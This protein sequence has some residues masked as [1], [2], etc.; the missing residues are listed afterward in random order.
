[1]VRPAWW[2]EDPLPMESPLERRLFL[3]NLLSG[4][5]LGTGIALPAR[6]GIHLPDGE[7]EDLN[8][9][10]FVIPN[11]ALQADEN[12]RIKK[13]KSFNQDF[14]EDI[15]IS[16]EKAGLLFTNAKRLDQVQRHVGYGNFNLLCFDDL[17]RICRRTR[18]IK[19]LTPRDLDFFEEIFTFNAQIYGFYG[20]KVNRSI[21]DRVSRREATKVAGTGHYLYRGESLRL[22]QQIRREMGPD[23]VLTSGIR[24][25]VKQMHL[26]LNKA[27]QVGGNLSRA[28]RSLAPPGHS[29]HGVGDFDVGKVGF[30]IHNFTNRFATT[31]EYRKLLRLG[32]VKIRY[33]SNNPYGVRYEPW[34]IKVVS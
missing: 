10:T 30:G 2:Q 24:S 14:S 17:I 9:G 23:I 15:Y 7:S 27:V 12:R 4:A 11:K 1:M 8:V 16:N 33:T 13:I 31:M 32:Y 29:Y 34:H 19:T 28:S 3:Q 26:F 6:A 22:Y 25:I 21:T 18:G 20:E 5:A